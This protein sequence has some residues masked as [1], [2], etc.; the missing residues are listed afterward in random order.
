VF[1]RFASFHPQHVEQRALGLLL[2]GGDFDQVPN[3]MASSRRSTRF[4]S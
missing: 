2:A 3:E 1:Q 4:H